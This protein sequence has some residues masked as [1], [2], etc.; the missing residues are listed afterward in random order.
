MS[1]AAAQ[2]TVTV[3]DRHP[4]QKAFVVVSIMLATIM[5]ALDT[6]IANVALPHMQGALSATQEQISWVLT[7]YIVSAAIMTAPTGILAARLGRRRL[8]LISVIGFT[9]A[10]MLCGVAQTLAEMVVFRLLQ[11]VFGAGLI[12]LSQAVLLDINPPEKHGQAMAM[13]GVGVMLGPILGPTLGGWLTEYYNWRWVFFINLPVGIVATL[14][15][16]AFMPETPKDLTRKFDLQGFLYLAMFVF[17][18]QMMLDRGETLDW[19]SSAE[20]MMECGIAILGIYLFVVHVMTARRPF[21]EPA[22]FAD[23]NYAVALMFIFLIGIILLSTMAL[24]PPYLQNLMGYPVM[25]TGEVLAPRGVGT[26]LSMMLAGRLLARKVDVRYMITAGLLLTA[27]SLYEMSLF[28]LEISEGML[29]RTGLI[30][31]F[32]MGLVFVPLSTIAYATL[33]GRYRN[34]ATS[35]F[36]LVRNIGSS[37]GIAVMI[38]LAARYTQINHEELG[39]RLS[40]LGMPVTLLQA[41]PG[42]AVN[43]QE[44]QG[45]ALLNGEVTRQAAAIS[46]LNDFRLMMYVVLAALPLLIMM[47]P[48]AKTPREVSAEQAVSSLE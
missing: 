15:M 31:G 44:A 45:L 16:I 9:L 7:S 18:V 25:T 48:P 24:L 19:F 40:P 36:S 32:G 10:S 12:P 28:N 8:F 6:T 27:Y 26:M 13:W 35:V 17:G 33:P 11:G 37:I 21:F 22:M 38:A 23:R 29:V 39:A 1:T 46:Y 14:G 4:L 5:Q 41:L 43:M 3:L 30:Q 20:V 2:H 47:R 34:D 42:H